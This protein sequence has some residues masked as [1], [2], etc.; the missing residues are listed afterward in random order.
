[1]YKVGQIERC[2]LS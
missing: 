1:M 2:P